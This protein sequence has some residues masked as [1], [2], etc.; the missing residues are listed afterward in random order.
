MSGILST[1]PKAKGSALAVVNAQDRSRTSE[2][3]LRARRA[4][5]HRPI[6]ETA[7]PAVLE[8]Q[9]ATCGVVH[10]HFEGRRHGAEVR[11]ADPARSR[12]LQDRASDRQDADIALAGVE[13]RLSS[14]SAV[15]ADRFV[16]ELP[17]SVIVPA[18]S[19][20]VAIQIQ[21]PAQRVSRVARAWQRLVALVGALIPA[22]QAQVSSPPPMSAG[23]IRK[24]HISTL[25]FREFTA[26]RRKPV[27]NPSLLRARSAAHIV[28]TPVL[29]LRGEQ[30]P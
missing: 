21:Q 9:A 7:S 23:A 24:Q 4:A 1:A 8:L 12:A 17:S 13:S 2:D 19:I 11:A 30:Q 6:V 28:A 22:R 25:G 20:S 18:A 10:R 5:C 27:G 29:P 14:A 26:P 16:K 3:C 15:V